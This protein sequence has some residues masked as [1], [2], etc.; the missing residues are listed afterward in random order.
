MHF[1]DI[2]EQ[3]EIVEDAGRVRQLLIKTSTTSITST[4]STASIPSLYNYM[5]RRIDLWT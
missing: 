4:A 1:K 2:K 3:K 5:K